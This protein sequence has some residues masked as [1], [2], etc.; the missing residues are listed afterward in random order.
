[1][2]SRRCKDDQDNGKDEIPIARPDIH[3]INMYGDFFDQPGRRRTTYHDSH[4]PARQSF[5]NNS[6]YS[7]RPFEPKKSRRRASSSNSY[8][9]CTPGLSSLESQPEKPT[10]RYETRFFQKATSTTVNDSFTTLSRARRRSSSAQPSH[11]SASQAT[12]LH[13]RPPARSHSRPSSPKRDAPERRARSRIRKDSRNPLSFDNPLAPPSEKQQH[14]PI[15]R[16][17]PWLRRPIG[18][19]T[20][21]GTMV[22]TVESDDEREHHE[23]GRRK[24]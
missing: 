23:S 6:K 5:R 16:I 4:E 18:E 2:P 3:D 20:R 7:G 17:W 19:V 1:M 14:G 9:I 8:D 24:D 15:L 13:N 22:V 10:S 12:T 21:R 11:F